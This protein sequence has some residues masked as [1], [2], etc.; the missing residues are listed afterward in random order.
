MRPG[1]RS[2]PSCPEVRNQ[3]KALRTADAPHLF[4]DCRSR[5]AR[6]RLVPFRHIGSREEWV[7]AEFTPFGTE[8]KFASLAR[9]LPRACCKS[10]KFHLICANLFNLCKSALSHRN[11]DERRA[12]T[13]FAP[14]DWHRLEK[15][16]KLA[17]PHFSYRFCYE[18]PPSAPCGLLCEQAV[19]TSLRLLRP[20]LASLRM[21][22]QFLATSRDEAVKEMR[23]QSDPDRPP[24]RQE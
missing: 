12:Q 5:G 3:H 1:S 21:R 6:R 18:L 17:N 20:A 16:E 10:P 11:T 19:S 22:G 9:I 23:A 13:R 2:R 8:P 4:Q 15:E 24:L 7:P 14:T